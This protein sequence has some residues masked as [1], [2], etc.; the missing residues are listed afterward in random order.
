MKEAASNLARGWQSKIDKETESQRESDLREG[1]K[2]GV[3]NS[4]RVSYRKTETER[5]MWIL[6]LIFT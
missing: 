5:E 3:G 1:E 2:V 6:K 4:Y